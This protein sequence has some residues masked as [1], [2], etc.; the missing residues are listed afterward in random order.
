MQKLKKIKEEII[1]YFIQETS[2]L[3]NNENAYYFLQ[4]LRIYL[5]QS[6]FLDDILKKF[7]EKRSR[8]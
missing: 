3:L 8:K 5:E 7:L 2:F 4:N 1:N 6:N